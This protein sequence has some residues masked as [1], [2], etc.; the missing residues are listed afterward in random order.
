MLTRKLLVGVST[1]AMAVAAKA[2][3]QEAQ[4][5]PLVVE[6]NQ[7]KP[8]KKAVKKAAPKKAKKAVPKKKAAAKAKKKK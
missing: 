3:A 2:I 4:L 5:P 1:L 8:K 7:P 6:G